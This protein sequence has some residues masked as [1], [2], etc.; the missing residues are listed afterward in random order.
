M[1]FAL[2][3]P[4]PLMAAGVIGGT[5]GGVI[6]TNTIGN[7][8][9]NYVMG[10][11]CLAPLG[12]AADTLQF[13]TDGLCYVP[14]SSGGFLVM[15][16]NVDYANGLYVAAG[17]QA[18][19]GSTDGLTL[20]IGALKF[21][22]DGRNWTNSSVGGVS[23]RGDAGGADVMYNRGLN[24]WIAA[25]NQTDAATNQEGAILTSAD[26]RTWS[27]LPAEGL[28]ALNFALSQGGEA[29]GV[30]SSGRTV[31]GGAGEAGTFEGDMV[32][33]DNGL[34]YTPVVHT[35]TCFAECRVVQYGNDLWVAGGSV[36]GTGG[37]PAA[38]I[39]FSTDNGNTWRNQIA[40]GNDQTIAGASFSG[41]CNAL[42]YGDGIW[43]AGSEANVAPPGP[44]RGTP[45]V[46]SI[47]GTNLMWSNDGINW[48]FSTNV[49]QANGSD[50]GTGLGSVSHI[51][52]DGTKWLAAGGPATA[53]PA[54]PILLQSADGKIWQDVPNTTT[55]ANNINPVRT[56]ALRP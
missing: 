34:C 16:S 35:G 17:Q 22:T 39:Q 41:A 48:N 38:R 28:T 51:L 20:G 24:L 27:K 42:A 2:N 14:S 1:A 3:I 23:F 45:P 6:G 44:P 4:G 5:V 10:G 54:D 43:V 46:A 36:A 19:P 31:V 18:A 50:G 21:S 29:I 9:P 8:V 55:A 13:S 7:H 32:V 30:G 52:Y 56:I 26:G 40:T 15:G 37:P 47:A 33:S 11:T 53:D 49:L 25:G 12:T